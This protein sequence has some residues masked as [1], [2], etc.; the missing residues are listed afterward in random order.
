[1][2]WPVLPWFEEVC[3]PPS[4]PKD[5]LLSTQR[6]EQSELEKVAESTVWYARLS[7]RRIQ[8]QWHLKAQ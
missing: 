8:S 1:M 4:S 2:P 5:R 3:Q 6:R 7:G